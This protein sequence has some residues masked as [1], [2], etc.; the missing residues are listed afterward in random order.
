MAVYKLNDISKVFKGYLPGK[1]TFPRDKL[2]KINV[3][4]AFSPELSIL[5]FEYPTSYDHGG[6]RSN[7]IFEYY[8]ILQFTRALTAVATYLL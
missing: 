7:S 2:Y 8:V 3:M 1:T 5:Y 6:Y 4:R